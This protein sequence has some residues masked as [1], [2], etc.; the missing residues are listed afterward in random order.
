MELHM[1]TMVAERSWVGA[2]VCKRHLMLNP[3]VAREVYC[4]H[5]PMQAFKSDLVAPKES[6][7]VTAPEVRAHKPCRRSIRTRPG[8]SVQR[9]ARLINYND[10]YYDD[11][12]CSE[13]ESDT[14][15]EFTE[16][17]RVIDHNN[18]HYA[19]QTEPESDSDQQTDLD[20]EEDNAPIVHNVCG[21][22]NQIQSGL[23]QIIISQE[24]TS[25]LQDVTHLE[26]TQR[27]H[28]EPGP[29][30]GMMTM[31]KVGPG[32]TA[33]IEEG[34]YEHALDC[35]FDSEGNLPSRGSCIR[36]VEGVH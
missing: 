12:Y 6:E 34:D 16:I 4:S 25:L 24:A 26:L 27:D 3:A 19:D 32:A 35:S 14:E 21:Y 31:M 15:Q 29:S 18:T 28:D 1:H 10:Y 2:T 23:G 7:A 33:Y 30:T 13:I 22:Y 17:T 9:K 36:V 5:L 20:L 11:D 8:L